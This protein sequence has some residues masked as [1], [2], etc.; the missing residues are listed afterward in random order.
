MKVSAIPA[1][2][3]GVVL[4]PNQM[5]AI[6]MTK[7]R[8]IR[9]ATEYV[10]G[11]VIDRSMNASMFWAKWKMPLKTNSRGRLVEEEVDGADVLCVVSDNGAE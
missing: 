11:E 5:M 9:D 2:W 10:T 3:T 7:T 6:T 1:A 4:L 8:L